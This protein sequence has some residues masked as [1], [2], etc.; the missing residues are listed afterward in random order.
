MHVDLTCSFVRVFLLATVIRSGRSVSWRLFQ[1]L[2]TLKI[3]L[4]VL[5]VLFL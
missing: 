2:E 3:D 1:V 5:T 4:T